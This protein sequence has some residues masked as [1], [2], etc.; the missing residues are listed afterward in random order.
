MAEIETENILEDTSQVGVLHIGPPDGV[1]TYAFITR[2]NRSYAARDWASLDVDYSTLLDDRDHLRRHRNDVPLVVDVTNVGKHFVNYLEH[3]GIDDCVA[4]IRFDDEDR[5]PLTF[6]NPES[7]LWHVSGREAVSA[8][9][10][11]SGEHRI[12]FGPGGFNR[13][14]EEDFNARI[15]QF[16]SQEADE[17]ERSLWPLAVACLIAERE[18]SVVAA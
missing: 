2:Q 8:L 15:E 17:G 1:S 11:L 18:Q 13:E 7:G 14:R 9:H 12:N 5:E 16:G 3:N 10:L 6:R 4:V